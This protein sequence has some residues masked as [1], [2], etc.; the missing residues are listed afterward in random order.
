LITL[1]PTLIKGYRHFMKFPT[2][3]DYHK[4]LSSTGRSVKVRHIF[5]LADCEWMQP[6]AP[7]TNEATPQNFFDYLRQRVPTAP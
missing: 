7:L 1:A 2:Q 3:G 4:A 5:G 6:P